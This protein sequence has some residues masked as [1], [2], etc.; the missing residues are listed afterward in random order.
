MSTMDFVD[1][2]AES[3]EIMKLSPAILPPTIKDL[4]ARGGGYTSRLMFPPL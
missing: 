3:L 1:M 4:I 2:L